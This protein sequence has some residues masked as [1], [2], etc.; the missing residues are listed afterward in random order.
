VKRKLRLVD[1]HS[2]LF[3]VCGGFAYWLGILEALI[4]AVCI[5]T[6]LCHG[7]GIVPYFI[8]WLAMSEWDQDP[9]DYEEIAG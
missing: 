6:I 3:G 5:F 2:W 4:R 1:Q 9:D 8:L 7:I